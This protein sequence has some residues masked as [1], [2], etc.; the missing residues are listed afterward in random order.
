MFKCKRCSLPNARITESVK[1]ILN[2]LSAWDHYPNPKRVKVRMS[3][4]VCFHSS[5]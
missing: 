3:D 2:D 1:G 5:F 4:T